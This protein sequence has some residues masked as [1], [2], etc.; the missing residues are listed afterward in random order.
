MTLRYE[1]L[2]RGVMEADGAKVR[3]HTI[4]AYLGS[5]QVAEA[6]IARIEETHNEEIKAFGLYF[7]ED[8]IAQPHLVSLAAAGNDLTTAI[9][10]LK[11]ADRFCRIE[12]GH[13]L[14]A[15]RVLHTSLEE[16]AFLRAPGIQYFGK[17]RFPLW[18]LM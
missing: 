4:A 15:S 10:L 12:Y 17:G 13:H 9:A 6:N 11:E 7:A 8:G 3:A 18:R 2:D 1:T 5:T 16:M 14:V